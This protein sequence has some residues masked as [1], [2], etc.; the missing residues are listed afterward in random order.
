MIRWWSVEDAVIGEKRAQPVFP[1]DH[2][3]AD[4]RVREVERFGL[5]V[6]QMQREL[7]GSRGR[8]SGEGAPAAV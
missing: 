3:A 2:R 7:G 5:P 6:A 1:R 4:Q 8:P